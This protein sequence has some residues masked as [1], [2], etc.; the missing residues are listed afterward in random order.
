[1]AGKEIKF[2]F[3]WIMKL[4]YPWLSLV[5]ITQFVLCVNITLENLLSKYSIQETNKCYIQG[6]TT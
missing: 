3:C 4:S 5:D 2:E 1:M 6:K